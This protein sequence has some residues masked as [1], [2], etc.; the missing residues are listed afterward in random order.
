MG[1]R[2][3]YVALLLPVTVAGIIN[4]CVRSTVECRIRFVQHYLWKTSLA[5]MD[6]AEASRWF[7]LDY[8]GH[9]GVFLLRLIEINH[10]SSVLTTIISM[11]YSRYAQGTSLEHPGAQG[12]PTLSTLD[13]QPNPPTSGGGAAP[14]PVIYSLH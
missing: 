11:L 2:W 9:D 8:L 12:S 13:L 14:Q 3:F 5:P 6:L 7:V 4:W 10:G 1:T